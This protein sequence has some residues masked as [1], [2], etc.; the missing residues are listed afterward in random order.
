MTDTSEGPGPSDPQLTAI[1]SAFTTG[2]FQLL[3]LADTAPWERRDS[4]VG[5]L[6]LFGQRCINE[7]FALEERAVNYGKQ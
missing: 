2:L 6:I 3:A 5:V 7:A 1:L 4:I